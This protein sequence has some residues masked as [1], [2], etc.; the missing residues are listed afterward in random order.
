MKIKVHGALVATALLL[1]AAQV[2]AGFIVSG[3][4]TQLLSGQ[5]NKYESDLNALGFDAV[6]EG[7]GIALDMTGK[8]TFR[9]HGVEAGFT[10]TFEADSGSVSDPRTGNTDWNDPVEIIG[11]QFVTS[12]QILDWE[13][14]TSGS[15]GLGAVLGD[16]GFGVFCKDDSLSVVTCDGYSASVLYIGFDDSGFD[17]PTDVDD[18]HDDYV[19]SAT[20]SEVP[21]PNALLLLALSMIGV[22]IASRRVR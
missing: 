13:F 12:G 2:Q 15:G 21:E 5:D 7:G 6:L 17:F 20:F 4:T 10:N 3:G 1:A 18:N 22:G 11:T 8:V 19:L 9:F 14:L 16:A